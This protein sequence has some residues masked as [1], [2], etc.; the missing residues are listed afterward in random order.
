MF[1]CN[2]AFLKDDEIKGEWYEESLDLPAIIPQEPVHD[3][4]LPKRKWD[5]KAQS[6]E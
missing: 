1:L 2:C 6:T 3:R 4:V 5:T